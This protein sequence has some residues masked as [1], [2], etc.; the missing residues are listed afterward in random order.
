[1]SRFEEL[2]RKHI[3]ESTP[4]WRWCMAAECRAGQV[5]VIKPTEE[6]AKE[7]SRSSFGMMGDVVNA[8]STARAPKPTK[9]PNVCVCQTCGSKA[10][11]DCDRPWHEGES[12]EA[13]QDRLRGHLGDEDA[14]EKLITGLTKKCPGCKG[15]I[16]KDGGCSAMFCAYTSTYLRIW[17]ADRNAFRYPLSDLLLLALPGNLGRSPWL[18]VCPA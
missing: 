13:Y 9:T 5:H 10:C 1:M 11:V 18:S 3:A 8:L 16:E 2:E 6:K 15:K 12:C 7:K 4:G 14:S 17:F